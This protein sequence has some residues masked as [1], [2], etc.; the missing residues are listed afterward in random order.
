[1]NVEVFYKLK[2]AKRYYD[3]ISGYSN[4]VKEIARCEYDDF[5]LV[6]KTIIRS[7]K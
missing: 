2:D 4:Q 3:I 5:D 1:M 6:R 7:N